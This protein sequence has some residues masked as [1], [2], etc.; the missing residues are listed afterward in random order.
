MREL[1]KRYEKL[2][3]NKYAEGWIIQEKNKGCL[4]LSKI[5]PE[6]IVSRPDVKL[7]GDKLSL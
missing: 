7:L 2:G 6:P 5:A 4:W 1:G 3:E